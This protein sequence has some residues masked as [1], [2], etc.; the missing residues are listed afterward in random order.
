MQ[1]VSCFIKEFGIL[2]QGFLLIYLLLLSLFFVFAF[3][4]NLKKKKKL[5]VLVKILNTCV[6]LI[7][8]CSRSC[9]LMSHCMFSLCLSKLSFS[10]VYILVDH[11]ENRPSDNYRYQRR[12]KT[13]MIGHNCKSK[14]QL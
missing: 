10:T 9:K 8:L 13:H 7:L 4:S 5:L 1:V 2:F 11:S 6:S 12:R 3:A 14:L